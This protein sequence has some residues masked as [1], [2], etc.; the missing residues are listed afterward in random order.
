MNG[1]NASKQNE[2]PVVPKRSLKNKI[3]KNPHNSLKSL[4]NSLLKIPYFLN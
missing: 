1:Q 2:P 3:H 4:G